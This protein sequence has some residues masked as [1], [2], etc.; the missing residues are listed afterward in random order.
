MLNFL[1][2]WILRVPYKALEH[3]IFI[4]VKKWTKLP[5]NY[6]NILSS[7]HYHYYY[8]YK[9]PH[10]SHEVIDCNF[11]KLLFL[12]KIK[13]IINKKKSRNNIQN[14]GF[15]ADCGC[16]M[17]T[18]VVNRRTANFLV[19]LVCQ[20]LANCTFKPNSRVT[21]SKV[22]IVNA[23]LA[24]FLGGLPRSISYFFPVILFSIFFSNFF[25]G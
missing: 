10:G 18:I 5:K 11:M 8:Y 1:G 2:K 14:V 24:H 7:K 6:A 23:W 20:N 12:T 4:D 9:N 15:S 21:T 19:C 3:F 17:C 16:I 13:L 25:F 22:W